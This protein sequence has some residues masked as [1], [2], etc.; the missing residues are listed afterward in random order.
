[1]INTLKLLLQTIIENNKFSNA[2][3]VIANAFAGFN[4][5]EVGVKQ[6]GELV[7]A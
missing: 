1:M 2:V 7:S 5:S 3:N 4:F 6:E